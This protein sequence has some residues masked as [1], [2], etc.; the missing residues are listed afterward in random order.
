MKCE[1]CNKE[2]YYRESWIW[3]LV[4][5]LM[6]AFIYFMQDFLFMTILALGYLFT[7]VMYNASRPRRPR[8]K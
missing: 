1:K 5:L 6:I 8:K 7:S 4:G 2:I 3:P